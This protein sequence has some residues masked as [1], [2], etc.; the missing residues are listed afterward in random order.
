M[1]FWGNPADTLVVYA[2]SENFGLHTNVVTRLKLWTTVHVDY[3][4]TASVVLELSSTK[5]MYMGANRFGCLWKKAVPNQPNYYGANF[6]Y[7]PMLSGSSVPSTDNVEMA[8][9]LVQIGNDVTPYMKET[10][11]QPVPTF[12]GPPVTDSD[13]AMDKVVGKLDACMWSPL[14][15]KDAMNL[16]LDIHNIQCIACFDPHI[17]SVNK[18]DILLNTQ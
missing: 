8:C 17:D 5:L 9:T 6:K 16:I 3:Q 15:T 2:L 7:Q 10:T 12:E 18:Q 11:L 1:A 14:N 4:G 13:D